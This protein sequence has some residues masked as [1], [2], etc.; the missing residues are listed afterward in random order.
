MSGVP[1][2]HAL[3]IIAEKKLNHEDYISS[4]LLNSRQQQIYSDSIRSVNGMC[5]WDKTGSVI[6]PPPILVEELENRKGRKPKPKGK[7]GKHESPKKKKATRERRVM[8]CRRCS[9][10]GHNAAKCPNAG[11]EKYMPPKKKKNMSAMPMVD[12]VGPSQPTQE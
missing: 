9:F 11:V 6:L 2:R 3:R 12:E 8:H 1:C 5:F 4:W 7:K 10:A